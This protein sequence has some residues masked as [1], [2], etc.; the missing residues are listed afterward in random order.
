MPGHGRC[1]IVSAHSGTCGEPVRTVLGDSSDSL[2]AYPEDYSQL[3]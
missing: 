1:T 2:N 3:D